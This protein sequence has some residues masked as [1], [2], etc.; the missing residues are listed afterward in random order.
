[1]AKRNLEEGLKLFRSVG[2]TGGLRFRARMG[3]GILQ[4]RKHHVRFLVPK[5]ASIALALQGLAAEE[6]MIA[7]NPKVTEAGYRWRRSL[8]QGQRVPVFAAASIRFVAF[9][10][11]WRGI[12]LSEFKATDFELGV[13][14]ELQ[15]LGKL[16][17]ELLTIP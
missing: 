17:R 3:R 15:D 11:I 12:N 14:L 2:S 6:T 5:H 8:D 13:W 10:H 16:Q 9:T 4:V 7:K 1:M